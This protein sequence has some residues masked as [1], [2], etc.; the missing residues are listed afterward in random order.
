MTLVRGGKTNKAERVRGIM[1]VLRLESYA[2]VKLLA[3][4]L[5][6]SEATVRR[7]LREFADQGVVRRTHGGA[8]FCGRSYEV[9]VRYRRSEHPEEKRRI[10]EAA[11]A[12]VHD[13]LVVGLTGG[14]TTSE[15]ARH[16][17]WGCT[18]TVLTNS[19]NIATELA[20]RPHVTLVDTGGV[21]RS[22]SFEL[23]GPV[24]EATVSRYHLD[25][26][27][28][29]VDGI[30]LTAGCTTHDDREAIINQAMVQRAD[31]TI[32]VADRSKIGVRAFAKICEVGD[33]SLLITDR[34]AAG[35]PLAA[36]KNAGLAIRNV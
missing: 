35:N 1:E 18:L 30:D 3:S 28:L 31:R 12:L 20:V 27:F 2:S 22:A 21:A 10:G 13:G 19:L 25:V 11:A 17:P 7:D 8:A 32:V 16:L 29:G 4:K 36:L 5:G 26:V 34:H 33:V 23:T 6:V 9:P 24:A 14:T 15:V